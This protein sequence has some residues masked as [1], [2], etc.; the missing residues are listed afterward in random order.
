MEG[1]IRAQ[2]AREPDKRGGGHRRP[3]STLATIRQWQIRRK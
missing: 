2:E 1:E 3:A